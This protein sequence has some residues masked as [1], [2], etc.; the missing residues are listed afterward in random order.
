MIFIFLSLVIVDIILKIFTPSRTCLLGQN[1]TNK[2]GRGTISDEIGP[3][4]E[5]GFFFLKLS[6]KVFESDDGKEYFTSRSF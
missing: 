5:F 2:K 6:H 1:N 4:Q 3:L